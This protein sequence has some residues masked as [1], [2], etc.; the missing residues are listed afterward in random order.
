[1]DSGHKV[2]IHAGAGG[3]GYIAIQLGKSFGAD[4]FA[5]VSAGKQGIIEELGAIPINYRA[6]SVEQYV[7]LHTQGQGFDIVYDSRRSDPRCTL[8]RS[9]A[10]HRPCR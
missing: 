1:V 2:L 7:D 9:Q 5:T 3:V 10:V 4:V 6:L 8:H